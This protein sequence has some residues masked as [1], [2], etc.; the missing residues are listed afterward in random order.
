MI[1][2]GR[3]GRLLSVEIFGVI[4]YHQFRIAWDNVEFNYSR[5]MRGDKS[6]GGIIVV[7]INSLSN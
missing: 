6:D 5:A 3:S 2:E 7:L 4:W 1:N